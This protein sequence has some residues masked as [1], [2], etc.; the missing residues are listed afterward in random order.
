MYG[1]V[2]RLKGDP[3]KTDE[4]VRTWTQQTLPL[5]KKQKGFAGVSLMGNRKTGDAL[6]VTYWETEQ[7][8]KDARPQIRPT[9]EKV[10]GQVGGRIIEEDEC[11]VAVQA[12]FE[13]PKSGVWAR[14]TTIEGDPAKTNQGISDYK[15]RVVP[16]IQKQPGGRAAVLLVN[17]KAG[18]SFSGT[19]WS[20]EKDLQ[21]SEAVVS[22]LRREVAEKAGA[23][24][25]KVEVFEVFHTEILAPALTRR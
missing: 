19:L 11:E 13:P 10:L 23:K 14:V 3:T 5:I 15:A 25:P 16:V 12:R 21:N 20:T 24:N 22:S 9:A 2:V 1:R 6:S 8:M 7:A 18:K 4:A 17:R